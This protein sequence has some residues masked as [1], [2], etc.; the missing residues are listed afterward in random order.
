LFNTE[1]LCDYR[2]FIASESTWIFAE[3][4]HVALLP[5]SCFVELS[6]KNAIVGVMRVIFVGPISRSNEGRPNCNVQV[7]SFYLRTGR[8]FAFNLRGTSGRPRLQ[9]K[10]KLAQVHAPSLCAAC[11]NEASTYDAAWIQA[12]QSRQAIN[13]RIKEGIHCLRGL[14]F[15]FVVLFLYFPLFPSCFPGA[16]TPL[17]AKSIRH[18]S[19]QWLSKRPNTAN[20][21][22]KSI[23]ERIAHRFFGPCKGLCYVFW[24]VVRLPADCVDTLIAFGQSCETPNTAE[25]VGRHWSTLSSGSSPRI[26]N[27]LLTISRKAVSAKALDA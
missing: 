13:K 11:C 5:G 27:V 2:V 4:R 12:E 18:V 23:T 6:N 10:W 8:S 25:Q 19:W 22:C 9:I 7:S 3:V 26:T 14:P 21:M 16:R 15:T 20:C 17:Q 24:D 1:Q